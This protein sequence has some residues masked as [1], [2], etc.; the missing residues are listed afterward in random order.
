MSSG[1]QPE[2]TQLPFSKQDPTQQ[3]WAE[4]RL[5]FHRVP[6]AEDAAK[7]Q[8]SPPRA[9]LTH[10]G[11]EQTLTADEA[12]TALRLSELLRLNEATC[13][14]LVR[15][16]QQALAALPSALEVAPPLVRAAYFYFQTQKTFATLLHT[17]L[18]AAL[19]QIYSPEFNSLA[20]EYLPSLQ[21]NLFH[22]LL[23]IVSDDQLT[24]F[25]RRIEAT[26]VLSQPAAKVCESGEAEVLFVVIDSFKPRSSSSLFLFALLPPTPLFLQATMQQIVDDARRE[27]CDCMFVL[28]ANVRLVPHVDG[29]PQPPSFGILRPKDVYDMLQVLSRIAHSGQETDFAV[30]SLLLSVLALFQVGI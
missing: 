4:W 17:L 28:A 27:L 1:P 26:G 6:L 25:L 23:A 20:A 12:A 14:G 3:P 22:H 19:T 8:A 7:L 10:G 21:H 16:S 24:P 13:A 9:V 11:A 15:D 18:A 29:A 5:V 2:L 30:S